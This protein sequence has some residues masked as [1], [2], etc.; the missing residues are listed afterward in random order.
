MFSTL[1]I[2][3]K[4]TE[5]RFLIIVKLIIETNEKKKFFH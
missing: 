2:I 4:K 3:F 1:L 5:F